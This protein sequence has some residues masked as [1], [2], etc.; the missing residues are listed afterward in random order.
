[1][2][3]LKVPF[4]LSHVSTAHLLYLHTSGLS[5]L[6]PSLCCHFDRLCTLGISFHTLVLHPAFLSLCL[7]LVQFSFTLGIWS[8]SLSAHHGSRSFKSRSQICFCSGPVLK[9]LKPHSPLFR[10]QI[11]R[12]VRFRPRMG[13]FNPNKV[14][15]HSHPFPHLL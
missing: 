4:L 15:C 11:M 13:R 3:S 8:D 12:S 9:W 6:S 1:M 7:G 10:F 2:A 5:F 14:L